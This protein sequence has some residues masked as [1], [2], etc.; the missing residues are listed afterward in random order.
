MKRHRLL[1]T[2]FEPSPL[3][4]EDLED[5]GLAVN[6]AA[7]GQNPE[8]LPAVEQFGEGFFIQ[9]ASEALAQWLARPAVLARAQQLRPGLRLG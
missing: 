9:F 8:W 4:N 6:G 1:F 3:A 2:R 5:V 7:L